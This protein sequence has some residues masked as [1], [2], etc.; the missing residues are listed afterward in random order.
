MKYYEIIINENAT[1]F[2]SSYSG[3]EQYSQRFVA[4]SSTL[5]QFDQNIS[6]LLLAKDLSYKNNDQ[7]YNYLLFNIN[8]KNKNVKLASKLLD[9]VKVP[10]WNIK[11]NLLL[12]KSKL[13]K[14]ELT[15]DFPKI[16]TSLE[17]LLGY[18]LKSF[19]IFLA[20]SSQSYGFGGSVSQIKNNV[21]ILR[22]CNGSELTTLKSLI[23]HELMHMIIKETKEIKRAIKDR[24]NWH[25]KY[26]TELYNM[27]KPI[28]HK[29]DD[30]IWKYID[31]KKL[32]KIKSGENYHKKF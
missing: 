18:K 24:D 3:L 7:L 17:T 14:N 26:I 31:W 19:K 4:R 5:F 1:K 10:D 20:Y 13:I 22:I 29:K 25:S 16:K 30:L 23:A 12:S 28:L 32:E 21:I 11:K 8:P 2:E 9:D 27:L 6:K 15:R